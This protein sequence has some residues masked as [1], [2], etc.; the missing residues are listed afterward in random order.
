MKRANIPLLACIMN[1]GAYGA[2]AHKFNAAGLDPSETQHGRS[3]F[4]GIARAFGHAGATVQGLGKLDAL[5]KEHAARGG[6]TVW[7]IHIADN[8]PSVMYRRLFYGEE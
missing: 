6:S 4:A 3:D 1:D 7:D 8:I 2:E 5:F